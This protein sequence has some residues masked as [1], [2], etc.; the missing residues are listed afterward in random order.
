MK[1]RRKIQGRQGE[2]ASSAQVARAPASHGNRDGYLRSRALATF[3]LLLFT[4]GQPASAGF[5]DFQMASLTDGDLGTLYT[6]FDNI[7]LTGGTN[8]KASDP[9]GINPG[10]EKSGKSQTATVWFNDD[11]GIGVRPYD[12]EIKGSKGISG[13]GGDKNEELIFEFQNSAVLGSIHLGLSGDDQY[14]FSDNS[15][16]ILLQVAVSGNWFTISQADFG[17]SFTLDNTLISDPLRRG[18][19]WFGHSDFLAASTLSTSTLVSK[20]KVRNTEDGE[21]YVYSYSNNSSVSVPEPTTL[22][23]LALGLAGIGFRRR[24]IH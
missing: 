10:E 5:I 2:L 3:A 1:T 24:Q 7:E 12:P 14:K 16:V 22:V 15:A 6:G 19:L 18:T 9:L 11:Y 13:K 17:D 23:L 21:L 20:L 8:L 4:I